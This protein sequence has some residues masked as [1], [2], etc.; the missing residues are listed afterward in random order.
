MPSRSPIAVLLMAYGSASSLEDDDVRSYLA[1]ILQFYRRRSP[2]NEEVQDLK[3]RYEAVGGS[4]LCDI[5][6]RI[7]E[8]TQGALDLA[9]PGVFKVRMAMKH[10]SPSIEEMACRVAADGF[11]RGVAVA[12]A[13]FH[14]PLSTEG[15]YKLVSDAN[16]ALPRP[17]EWRCA[18]DWH[19][20]PTFLELWERRIADALSSIDGDPVVV[21]TNHSLPARIQEGSDPY[22]AQFEATAGALAD[23]QGLENW[24][25][26]YQSAGR[27]GVPWLGPTLLDVIGQWVQRG[28]ESFMVVPIGFL[29]DH[30]EILYDLDV[31]AR[32]TARQLGIRLY[33]TRMPN[34]DPSLVEMLVDV[35]LHAASG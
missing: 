24:A 7:V 26:A 28:R 32:E 20:H 27:G 5:T 21:F 11:E 9:Q 23:R 15:Y 35:I 31:E 19:L 8:G 17:L 30:L 16:A 1:H 33:R 13:P 12:L 3:A 22:T 25:T 14:S 18:D 2:T 34:D 6:A 4:P 29:M 10:S